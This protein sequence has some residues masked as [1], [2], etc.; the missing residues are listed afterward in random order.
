METDLTTYIYEKMKRE[1]K[2]YQ[3][4]LVLD[5]YKRTLEIYFV[6]AI[7]TEDDQQVQDINGQVNRNNLLQFEE[8]ICFYDENNPKIK[9]DNYLYAHPLD[10]NTG[11]EKGEVNAVLKHLN[12]LIAQARTQLKEFLLDDNQEEFSLSWNKESVQ[13]TIKTMRETGRYANE[14]LTF[15]QEE[16]ESIVDKFKEEQYDGL[17]R[18]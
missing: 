2:N 6:I 1:A 7:E 18:I 4:R 10:A 11:I 8:V 12:L 16:E 3:W 14:P 5:S 9:P 15:L 13:N 17:E